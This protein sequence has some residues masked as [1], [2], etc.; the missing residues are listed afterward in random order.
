M[1]VS[2]DIKWTFLAFGVSSFAYSVG[3]GREGGGGGGDDNVG[4]LHTTCRPCMC[5]QTD[6]EVC[7]RPIFLTTYCCNVGEVAMAAAILA[8]E[9]LFSV[10][11]VTQHR[12][13]YDIWVSFWL[14][15]LF[16]WR[17]NCRLL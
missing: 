13:L 6:K 14:A 5:T 15:A 10:F 16:N 2:H 12:L 7:W 1:A 17:V 8:Q 9:K 3:D 4:R 11:E